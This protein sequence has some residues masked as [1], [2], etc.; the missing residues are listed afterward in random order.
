MII[1]TVAA[2]AAGV[3]AGVVAA[4]A[5]GAGFC[6][7]VG[8]VAGD[9]ETVSAPLGGGFESGGVPAVSVSR[10]TPIRRAA[11]VVSAAHGGAR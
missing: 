5:A 8:C 4:V 10:K 9:G 1:V 11:R 6:A 3:V 7:A 2:A